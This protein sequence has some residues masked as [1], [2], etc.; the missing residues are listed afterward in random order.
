MKMRVIIT[1]EVNKEGDEYLKMSQECINDV[2]RYTVDFIG[3]MMHVE[4]LVEKEL[5]SEYL[6]FDDIIKV[7]VEG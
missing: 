1:K 6:E 7:E 2:F 3:K 4:I 5:K